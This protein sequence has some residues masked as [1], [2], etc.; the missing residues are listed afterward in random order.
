M[1]SVKQGGIRYHFVS[2]WY[3]LTWDLTPSPGSL[4]NINIYYIYTLHIF[5]I[6]YSLSLS[7][8]LYIYIYMMI[9]LY[10]YIYI[11]KL[12]L[13]CLAGIKQQEALASTRTQRK[14]STRILIETEPSPTLNGRPLKF[15]DKLKNIGS[16][17]SS[18]ESNVSIRQVKES[19][20]WTIEHVEV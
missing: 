20:Q 9:F 18:T 3:D 1:L 2:L 12:N 7:L 16:C 11:L 17:I 5:Y 10:I 15:V 14:W 19:Y 13:R 4:A 6:L 8:S